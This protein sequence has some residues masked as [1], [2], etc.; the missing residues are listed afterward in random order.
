MIWFILTF[1]CGISL[2]IIVVKSA[3]SNSYFEDLSASFTLSFIVFFLFGGLLLNMVIFPSLNNTIYI[4]DPAKT[5]ELIPYSDGSYYKFEGDRI[6]YLYEEP[7]KGI[8]SDWIYKNDVYFVESDENP[9]LVRY[10]FG[11]KREFANILFFNPFSHYTFYGPE[12][13]KELYEQ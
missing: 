4:E 10:C 5:V 9:K 2:F 3:P 7:T 11:F 1:V 12:S 8:I 6:Y 13:F